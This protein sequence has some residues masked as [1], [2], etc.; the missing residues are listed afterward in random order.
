MVL[1]GR[2]GSNPSPGAKQLVQ[3]PL[4]LNSD[5]LSS[6]RPCRMI[7]AFHENLDKALTE[8]IRTVKSAIPNSSRT[9]RVTINWSSRQSLQMSFTD[10][11]RD[12]MQAQC[13]HELETSERENTDTQR[14]RTPRNPQ[15]TP[16]SRVWFESE[17]ELGRGGPR[18]ILLI[19]SS[20]VVM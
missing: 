15:R 9:C 19:T 7:L 14:M 13:D 5:C 1:W 3:V 16:T 8:A 20:E 4:R 10:D 6:T 11:L 18:R 17:P 2:E 12:T